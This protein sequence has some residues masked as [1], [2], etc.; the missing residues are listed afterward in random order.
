MPFCQSE[1]N[2]R[3]RAVIR[4]GLGA[5]NGNKGRYELVVECSSSTLRY[6]SSMDPPA[7]VL[8]RVLQAGKGSTL[9]NP[10]TTSD[11]EICKGTY[12]MSALST[13][14]SRRGFY[15]N[16]PCLTLGCISAL[17]SKDESS[18]ID[19]LTIIGKLPHSS[20]DCVLCKR[21]IVLMK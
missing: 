7:I 14:M 16:H 17:G 11:A 18:V 20:E 13:S 1:W 5:Y 21:Q 8:P 2:V 10:T 4:P 15:K 12:R 6:S 3:R 19:S 9:Q